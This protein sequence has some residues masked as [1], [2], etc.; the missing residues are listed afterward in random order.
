M[1]NLYKIRDVLL[2]FIESSLYSSSIAHQ[3]LNNLS[4]I[5]VSLNLQH[6]LTRS[7]WQP[8]VNLSTVQIQTGDTEP[9]SVHEQTN[10]E[11]TRE[12]SVFFTACSA[13]SR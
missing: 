11:S 10:W 2:K 6:Y 1:R 8:P 13:R 7:V 9:S 3:E 4:P 5:S 12:S